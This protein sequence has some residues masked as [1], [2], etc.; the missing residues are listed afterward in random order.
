ML[1]RAGSPL[2]G[3][4]LEALAPPPQEPLVRSARHAL[5]PEAPARQRRSVERDGM[6]PGDAEVVVVV[7]RSVRRD[8]HRSQLVDDRTSDQGLR[9]AVDLVADQEV[10]V[11]AVGHLAVGRGVDPFGDPGA[12]ESGAG[13]PTGRELDPVG[14]HHRALRVT[15][16]D[17]ELGGERLRYPQVVGVEERDVVAGGTGEAG[18][19]RRSEALVRARDEHDAVTELAGPRHG[20]VGRAVVDDD[21]LVPV[22]GLR[23]Y[24]LERLGKVPTGVERSD[25]HAHQRLAHVNARPSGS[26]R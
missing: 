17:R 24:A 26:V 18:V 21:H 6:H 7:L 5:G 16:R 22:V 20:V 3:Q 12:E 10:S 13:R 8:A 19:P 1:G 14:D 11:P 2:A 25:H 4:H 23:E 15:G 9:R